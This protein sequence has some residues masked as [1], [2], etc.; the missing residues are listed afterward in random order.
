MNSIKALNVGVGGC[1]KLQWDGRPR[2]PPVGV[3]RSRHQASSRCLMAAWWAWQPF[4]KEPRGTP[5]SRWPCRRQPGLLPPL[6]PRPTPPLQDVLTDGGAVV[7]VVAA[8]GHAVPE[9]E[10][11]TG[12]LSV[13]AEALPEILVRPEAAAQLHGRPRGPT[14]GVGPQIHTSGQRSHSEGL[15]AAVGPECLRARPRLGGQL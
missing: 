13:E 12:L 6:R 5:S 7:E 15:Q 9:P 4:N 2:T 8:D 3:W 1:V 14:P 11:A 10:G